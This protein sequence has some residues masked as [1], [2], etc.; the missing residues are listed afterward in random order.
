MP[1]TGGETVVI[2][3]EAAAPAGDSWVAFALSDDRSV[4]N[5]LPYLFYL[6]NSMHVTLT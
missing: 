3:L 6:I 1:G 4:V 5:S 2:E